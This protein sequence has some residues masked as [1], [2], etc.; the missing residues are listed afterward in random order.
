M[1]RKWGLRHPPRRWAISAFMS[2]VFVCIMLAAMLPAAATDGGI[3]TEPVGTLPWKITAVDEE[4]ATHEESSLGNVVAD[5]ARVCLGTDI[6]IICGGDITGGLPPGEITWGELHGVF[7]VDRALATASVTIR[8]LRGMLES[9]LSHI[10]LDDSERIDGIQSSF[11]GFPQI[12]GFTL[13]YDASF[14]PG[15]RVYDIRIGGESLD[16]DSEAQNLT[17]AA[18][19][20]MLG[21]GYGIPAADNAV[22]SGMTLSGVTA[23]YIGDGMPEFNPSERRITMRGAFDS[24]LSA[25]LPLQILPFIV[26]VFLVANVS[27]GRRV[28]KTDTRENTPWYQ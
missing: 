9:G 28:K 4:N 5:A 6:A 1:M 11:D 17:I 22:A 27:R 15:E 26:I 7:T 19:E 20:F 3:D 24:N 18:S 23:I 10:T 12:S 2:I 14:A 25:Y 16:L 8:E 21:G 13:Y